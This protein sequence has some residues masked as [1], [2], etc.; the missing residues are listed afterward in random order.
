MAKT[1]GLH[2]PD[3]QDLNV[4]DVRPRQVLQS[5]NHLL[6]DHA[7][8]TRFYEDNGYVL[9][10]Q[11]LNRES[12]IEAR[13]AMLAVAARHGLVEPGDAEAKWTGKPFAG[14]MEESPEFNGISLRLVEHPDNL[15]VLAKV[16]G[17]KP[18]MVPNVQYRTYPPHGPVTIVHQDGFYSPG[19]QDYKPVWIPLV[20]CPKEVGGLMVAVGQ[21]K[22]GY[23]HNLAKPTPF[24]VPVGVIPEDSW[25]TTDYEPGDV[26]LVHPYSP[27]A[28]M[29]NTSDRLRITFDTR[30][31]SAARPSAVA[32]TVVAVTPNSITLDAEVIG[33]RT[34]RVDHDTY[35]RPIDPGI[36][37]P[38]ERFAEVTKPGMRLVA[39]MDNDYLVML[40]KATAL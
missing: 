29:P 26:L 25:A 24:P 10:R 28:S 8:L 40:R 15:K 3:A 17:E 23:F 22:R 20:P 36:R 38:F 21:N 32:A 9:L 7:A 1:Q 16:L 4:R 31:Q 13:D 5:C 30:V 34:L 27:H 33:R 6:D 19:I 37:E 18:C 39:V 12:V 2:L 14:G 35:L 11:V